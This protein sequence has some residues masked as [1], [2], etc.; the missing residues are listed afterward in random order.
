MCEKVALPP[1]DHQVDWPERMFHMLDGIAA[2]QRQIDHKIEEI[3]VK[4]AE[5]AQLSVRMDYV[6]RSVGQLCTRVESMEGEVRDVSGGLKALNA[7]YATRTEY[8]Q[9]DMDEVRSDAKDTQKG[10][11][12]NREKIFEIIKTWGPWI[13]FLFLFAKD[14]IQNLP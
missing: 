12:D 7:S 1:G 13:G 2:R 10:V 5:Q 8:Q 4:Q 3:R 6:E 11:H 9:R 14:L